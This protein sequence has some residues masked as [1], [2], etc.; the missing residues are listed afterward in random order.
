MAAAVHDIGASSATPA[1]AMAAGA[2]ALGAA[3]TGLPPELVA[4]RDMMREGQIYNTQLMALQ[5]EIQQENRRFST[6]SNVS[7]ARHDTAK[8]AVSNIRA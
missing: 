3:A 2:G 4:Q 7:R 1:V 8:A 6:L 5:E